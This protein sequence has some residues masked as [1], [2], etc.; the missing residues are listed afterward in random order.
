[1]GKPGAQL[2]AAGAGEPRRKREEQEHREDVHP[3]CQAREQVYAERKRTDQQGAAVTLQKPFVLK[4][5]SGESKQQDVVV[6]HHVLHVLEKCRAE[7]QRQHA[8]DLLTDAEPEKSQQ[9]EANQRSKDTD[10]NIR[11][12]AD[13]DVAHRRVCVVSVKG[14]EALKVGADDVCRKHEEGLADP[15]PAVEL[16]IATVEAELRVVL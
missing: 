2:R 13:E 14:G 11:A 7:N 5:Q 12:V 4:R 10:Q 15:V 6:L 16:S 3:G 8:R 1:M 9:A